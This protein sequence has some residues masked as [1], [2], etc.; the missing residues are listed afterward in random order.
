MGYPLLTRLGIN[1]FWYNHW[2]ND[3]SYNLNYKQSKII[4]ELLKIYLNYG[5][6]FFN[7][8]YV[9]EYFFNKSFKKYRKFNFYKNVKFYRQFFYSNTIL[10]IEHSYYLRYKTGEFFPGK[11]WF[12]S[13][14]SWIIICF[15]CFKPQKKK[16][17]IN[18]K[19]KKEV[20]SISLNLKSENKNNFKNRFKLLYKYLFQLINK[21]YI[22][23]F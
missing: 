5:L 1:Q 14:S 11:F 9:H 23:S 16:V 15:Q 10:G 18:S 2:Y 4:I 13:Y 6:T 12:I 3:F 8:L 17:G 7:N 22:Y 19:H 20:Y 21:N